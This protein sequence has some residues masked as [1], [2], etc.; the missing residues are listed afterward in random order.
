MRD[1]RKRS[2]RSISGTRVIMNYSRRRKQNRLSEWL[3]SLPARLVAR[4]AYM[5]VRVYN[6][7]MYIYRDRHDSHGD[8]DEN[9]ACARVHACVYRET[10]RKIKY[11]FVQPEK[12]VMM[13]HRYRDAT[14]NRRVSIIE[15]D[16][17]SLI[18]SHRICVR[19]ANKNLPEREISLIC[20]KQ[21][22]AAKCFLGCFDECWGKK[23]IKRDRV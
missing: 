7:Y 23:K 4:V 12:E 6:T 15:K 1:V 20:A 18:L 5:L 10:I 21:A 13:H 19:L 8:D 3:D 2:R 14:R 16:E 11:H 17:C 22:P 9:D